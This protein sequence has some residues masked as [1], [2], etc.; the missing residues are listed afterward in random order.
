[1]K[2]NRL[3]ATSGP[4]GDNYSLGSFTE[5]QLCGPGLVDGSGFLAAGGTI[6]LSGLFKAEG[7]LW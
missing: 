4:V 7:V 1:M 5:W 2:F 6:T 3:R